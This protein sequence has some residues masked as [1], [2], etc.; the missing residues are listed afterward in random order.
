MISEKSNKYIA[1]VLRYLD[2]KL[3]PWNGCVPLKLDW[4][5]KEF[6][7]IPTIK[8]LNNSFS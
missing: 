2:R 1:P 5:A 7:Y 6:V 3:K 8:I 4:I